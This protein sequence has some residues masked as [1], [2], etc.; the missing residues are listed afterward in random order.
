VKGFIEK[1]FTKTKYL[2]ER[3]RGE[4]IPPLL[5]KNLGRLSPTFF[6]KAGGFSLRAR[7]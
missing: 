6:R 4:K 1:S 3:E 7:S 2:Y 5:K